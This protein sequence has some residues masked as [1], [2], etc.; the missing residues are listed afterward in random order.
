[1]ATILPGNGASNFPLKHQY[2]SAKLHGI[3]AQKIL[4]FNAELEGTKV[5]I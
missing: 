5:I 4:L 2:V 3:T 1:M